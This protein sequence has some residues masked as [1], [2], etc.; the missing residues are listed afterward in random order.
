M[1]KRHNGAAV[2]VIELIG[3]TDG[4]IEPVAYLK[5]DRCG[6]TKAGGRG[7]GGDAGE[8]I[9]PVIEL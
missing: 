4:V 2:S 8:W 1:C 9:S 5:F 3:C 7:R 6:S